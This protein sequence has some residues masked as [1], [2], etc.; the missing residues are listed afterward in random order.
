M[1]ARLR[2]RWCFRSVLGALAMTLSRWGGFF[3]APSALL[4]RFCKTGT[5][6]VWATG[7][8]D[9]QTTLLPVARTPLK[10]NMRLAGSIR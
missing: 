7:V 4:S 8:R 1:S 5:W 2:L 6:G 10:L 9:A 3:F